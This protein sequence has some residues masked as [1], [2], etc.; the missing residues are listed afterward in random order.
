M[1]EADLGTT[2]GVFVVVPDGDYIRIL[3]SDRSRALHCHAVGHG[4]R[5]RAG[6]TPTVRWTDNHPE[7]GTHPVWR[8]E[9]AAG[10]IALKW[11]PLGE[12]KHHPT[13]RS[14][15]LYL[16][17]SDSGALTMSEKPYPW[18]LLETDS[19]P[20]LLPADADDPVAEPAPVPTAAAP[21][22]LHVFGF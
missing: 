19:V 10:S 12:Y 1:W 14:W 11:Y 4:V 22:S 18:R 9:P 8:P 16:A 17:V 6:H 21:V 13:Y 15:N 5:R 7:E 20:T 3:T 2:P